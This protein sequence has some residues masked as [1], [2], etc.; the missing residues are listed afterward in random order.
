MARNL[1]KELSVI[2]AY[3]EHVQKSWN[4]KDDEGYLDGDWLMWQE[5]I[6]DLE[7]D[8]ETLE[9]QIKEDKL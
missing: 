7:N 6:T 1:T 9:A 5:T 2:K 4:G 8:I 3:L